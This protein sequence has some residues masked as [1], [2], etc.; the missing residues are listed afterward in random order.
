VKRYAAID[1][2]TNT[3]RFLVVDERSEAVDRGS[4]ITRLG[5]GVDASGSIDRDAMNRTLDAVT[6]F[7]ERAR[8]LGAESIRIAGTSALRDARNGA[9]FLSEVREATGLDVEIL[10]GETEGRCAYAGATGWL[11]RG[12]YVVCDI[13]GGSTELITV[14][15]AVSIDVG[16]VR[17][18]ERFFSKDPP[19][20]SEIAAAREYVRDAIAGGVAVLGRGREQLIGVAGT[21][22]TLAALALGLKKYDRERVHGSRLARAD[23]EDWS[24]RLLS[25]SAE[26]IAKIGPVAPGREDVIASGSLILSIVME[27]LNAGDVLVSEHDILDGLV[28]E[29]IR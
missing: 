10:T 13:G 15:N 17:V 26:E 8:E 16:S 28:A 1:V 24:R 27:V 2:G 21:I 25:T 7:V 20:P 9:D 12:D 14:A 23:V 4:R 18:R 19:Q 29:L 5:K 3:V 22:T 11:E 6:T